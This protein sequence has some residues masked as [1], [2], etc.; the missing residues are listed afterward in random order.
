MTV[1]I[2]LLKDFEWCSH[3]KDWEIG[4]HGVEMLY[5]DETGNEYSS[6]F[7]PEVAKEQNWDHR[8]TILELLKKSGYRRS[9]N[10]EELFNKIR[11]K[12]YSSEKISASYQAYK[13]NAKQ[14][15]TVI[16]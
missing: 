1:S 13:S 9:G 12:R 5:I 4:Q 2:S 10:N 11:L 7:L 14:M 3:W 6:T 16:N 8:I 15:I